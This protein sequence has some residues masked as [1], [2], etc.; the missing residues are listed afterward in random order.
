MRGVYQSEVNMSVSL[1]TLLPQRLLDNADIGRPALTR[2]TVLLSRNGGTSIG[3]IYHQ[4]PL[5]EIPTI[6]LTQELVVIANP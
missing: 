5:G 6:F 1:N 4:F 2:Y 3:P